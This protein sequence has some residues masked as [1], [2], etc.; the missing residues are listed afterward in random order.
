MFNKIKYLFFEWPIRNN[1]TINTEKA[2]FM[3]FQIQ[4]KPHCVVGKE[5]RVVFFSFHSYLSFTI[6]ALIPQ[7]GLEIMP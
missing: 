7:D 6:S 3:G 1:N 4:H 5:K 2:N